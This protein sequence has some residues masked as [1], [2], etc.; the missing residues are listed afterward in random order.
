M[1][2]LNRYIY[3]YL[4]LQRGAKWFRFR[5]SIHHPLGFNW[6]PFEGPGVCTYVMYEYHSNLRH[7]GCKTSNDISTYIYI[8]VWNEV[9]FRWDTKPYYKQYVVCG[10]YVC[11][12][13]CLSRSICWPSIYWCQTKMKTFHTT[14]SLGESYMLRH[15][16]ISSP[17]SS[18][19]LSKPPPS[20]RLHG[21]DVL[22]STNGDEFLQKKQVKLEVQFNNFEIQLGQNMDLNPPR[23]WNLSPLTTKNRSRGWN[24]TRLEGLGI[25]IHIYIYQVI[26]ISCEGNY[27]LAKSGW[28]GGEVQPMKQINLK[29]NET[30]GSTAK[31]NHQKDI[32]Y[33]SK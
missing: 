32:P 29:G 2:N 21:V 20:C 31:D 19:S 26:Y 4:H 12:C 6:H 18:S 8:Y 13:V 30:K 27:H 14:E 1:Q 16:A 9:W 17:S 25:Y 23:V 15:F 24:L 22:Q 7:I 10:M 33:G 5:V 28:M 11:V 3:I